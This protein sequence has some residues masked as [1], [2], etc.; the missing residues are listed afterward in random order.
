M[1]YL[2]VLEILILDRIS[3]FFFYKRRVDSI[4]IAVPH[5]RRYFIYIH[6]NSSSTSPNLNITKTRLF[7]YIENFTTKKRKFSDEKF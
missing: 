4:F 2:N 3:N 7:N 6:V 5:F 1:H